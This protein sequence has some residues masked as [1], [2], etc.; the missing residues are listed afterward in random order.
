[1]IQE[2]KKYREELSRI[3]ERF[4]EIAID[5]YPFG[6]ALE[7]EDYKYTD[8][9]SFELVIILPADID[10]KIYPYSITIKQ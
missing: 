8:I 7:I 4:E 2:N 5:E 3:Q 10:M 9:K 1:M 6:I